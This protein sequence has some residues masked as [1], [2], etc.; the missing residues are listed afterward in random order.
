MVTQEFQAV[1]FAGGRGTR[2]PDIIGDRPKCLL[3][4][5]PVPLLWYPLHTLEK[6]GFQGKFK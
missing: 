5:G 2:C 3:P 6:H 1:V 4:I